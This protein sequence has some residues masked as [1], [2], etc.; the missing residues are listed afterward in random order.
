MS[1]FSQGGALALYSALTFPQK[2]AGVVGLS[3]W[4]PLNSSFPAAKKTP[5]TL[6]ILQCHGDCDPVV[7]YKW[8]QMTASKLKTLLKDVEFKSYRGLMHTSSDEELRDVRQFIHK[9]LP[10]Q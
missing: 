1:G 3:C 5:D 7:P 8:G 10:S 6:P 4:I 9:H 2:L